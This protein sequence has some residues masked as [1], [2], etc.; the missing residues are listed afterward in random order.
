MVEIWKHVVFSF[1][2]KLIEL[3]LLLPVSTAER[4]ISVMNFIKRELC[5]KIEDDWMNGLMVCYNE[6]EMFK[7]VNDHLM[8]L[9]TGIGHSVPVIC[10]AGLYMHKHHVA[11]S[12]IEGVNLFF[13]IATCACLASWLFHLHWLR[14]VYLSSLLAAIILWGLYLLYC[15][16]D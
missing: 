8:L 10:A 11:T 12:A 14:L 4:R 15:L 2:Y 7:S 9:V 13:G 1:V 16:N 6:K 3:A 5:N